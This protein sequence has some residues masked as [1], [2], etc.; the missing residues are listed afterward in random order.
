MCVACYSPAAASAPCSLLVWSTLI[1]ATSRAFFPSIPQ[2]PTSTFAAA[3]A[4]TVGIVTT[5]DLTC[6]GQFRWWN[7][8]Q[9]PPHFSYLTEADGDDLS[10]LCCHQVNCFFLWSI[11]HAWVTDALLASRASL[12]NFLAVLP[13]WASAYW[14]IPY[15]CYTSA[16][17]ANFTAVREVFLII[18][19]RPLKLGNNHWTPPTERYFQ[20]KPEESPHLKLMWI[21]HPHPLVVRSHLNLTPIY[22]QQLSLRN[23]SPRY[24]HW[25]KTTLFGNLYQS[26]FHL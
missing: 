16:G 6:A 21:R 10:S 20:L 13:V 22:Q 8:A 7:T 11:L 15:H 12:P 4:H 26:A 25:E 18:K 5:P 17:V 24:L 19:Q 14:L 3:R 23:L 9:S 1:N 2:K